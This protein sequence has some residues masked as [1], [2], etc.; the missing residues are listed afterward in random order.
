M[1][2]YID[3]TALIHADNLQVAAVPFSTAINGVDYLVSKIRTRCDR[4]N[5][6]AIYRPPMTSKYGIC[7]EFGVFLDELQSLPGQLIITGNLN[8]PGDETHGIDVHLMEIFTPRNIVQRVD[9]S[10]FKGGGNSLLDLIAHVE[11]SNVPSA[12]D[13]IDVDFSD[14]Y[15]YA[16][17]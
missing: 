6:A 17:R 14:H 13:V 2:P 8:C 11:G 16:D 15:I 10:T 1:H 4:V 9:K 3:I 7:N 5:P 12:V